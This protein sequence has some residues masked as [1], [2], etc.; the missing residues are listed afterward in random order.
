[1]CVPA[2]NEVKSV[3]T[4]IGSRVNKEW[5]LIGCEMLTLKGQFPRF[6][7]SQKSISQIKLYRHRILKANFI[8]N[9]NA[10]PINSRFSAGRWPNDCSQSAWRYAAPGSLGSVVAFVMSNNI[11]G[12]YACCFTIMKMPYCIIYIYASENSDLFSEASGSL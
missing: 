7:V 10:F 5:L 1:M 11:Q 3:I 6:C 2:L 4:N 9:P 8:E 12:Y